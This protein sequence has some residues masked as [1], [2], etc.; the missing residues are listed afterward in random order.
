VVYQ[1]S[2][3]T[4]IGTASDGAGEAAALRQHLLLDSA[5]K[6]RPANRGRKA[7]LQPSDFLIILALR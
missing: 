4:G 2:V 5:Q 3:L 1:R 7:R 6:Q